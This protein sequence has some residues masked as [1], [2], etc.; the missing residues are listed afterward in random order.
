MPQKEQ[1]N[2]LIFLKNQVSYVLPCDGITHHMLNLSVQ[3]GIRDDYNKQAFYCKSILQRETNHGTHGLHR[4]EPDN[5]PRFRVFRV[6]S[7]CPFSC[8]ISL[9]SAERNEPQNT[10]TAQKGTDQFPRFRIL[11]IFAYALNHYQSTACVSPHGSR[12]ILLQRRGVSGL[13]KHHIYFI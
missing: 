6:V 9:L 13:L 4:K 11:L 2:S 12:C 1:K 10:R 7:G 8:S 3:A 5:F